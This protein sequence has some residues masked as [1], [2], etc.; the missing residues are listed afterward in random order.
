MFIDISVERDSKLFMENPRIFGFSCSM[1]K[2][3][4][5]ELQFGRKT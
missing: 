2:N 5:K 4:P 1:F 3:I